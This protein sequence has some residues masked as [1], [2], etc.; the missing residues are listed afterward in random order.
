MWPGYT[1]TKSQQ[2]V[3]SLADNIWWSL[4]WNYE[5]TNWI[6]FS[7]E[8]SLRPLREQSNQHGEVIQRVEKNCAVCEINRNSGIGFM[9]KLSLQCSPGGQGEPWAP[10]LSLP[11]EKMTYRHRTVHGWQKQIG[12]SSAGRN[13]NSFLN[14]FRKESKEKN[15]KQQI[16]TSILR[17]FWVK[18]RRETGQWWRKK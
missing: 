7:L 18:E 16:H 4:A 17:S 3:H 14:W 8:L 2:S 13:L 1:W 5:L 6:I 11:Y 10:I 15:S 12:K 9:T